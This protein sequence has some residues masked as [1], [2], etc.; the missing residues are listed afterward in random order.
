MRWQDLRRS[1]NVEDQRAGGA[2]SGGGFRLGGCG[3]L[4]VIIISV[5]FKINPL[6]LLGLLQQQQQQQQ[7]PSSSAPQTPGQQPPAND[8]Q[9]DFVKAILGDTEDTWGTLFQQMGNRYE[10]PKLILFRDAVQSACGFANAAVGPFYCSSDEHVYLDL[11]FFDELS[12]R[13]G[14]PGDFARAYV[15][16]HEVGHHVQNLIGISE[17]IQ[18]QRSQSDE[19]SSNALSVRVELQADCFAGVWGYYAKKKNVLEAGDVEAAL[20]AATQIGDDRLQMESRGYVSPES[21][22]HGSS[23]QRVRWFTSGLN[24][25]DINNCNTFNSRNL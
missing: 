10:P 14:A 4:L 13:F 6:E 12:R 7:A 5:V 1:G 19:Q 9:A 3:L 22:T 25:G 8:T 16:A 2:F 21:F 20:N 11:G 18:Q 23:E 24:S 17:K 15:I